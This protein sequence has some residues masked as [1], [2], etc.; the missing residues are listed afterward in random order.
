MEPQDRK[1]LFALVILILAIAWVGYKGFFALPG[2]SQFRANAKELRA[3]R[4]QLKERVENAEVQVARMD[5]IKREQEALARQLAE[6]SRRLPS[7]RESA[8]VLRGVQSLAGRAGLTVAQVRRRPER[9]QELFVELPMEVAVGGNYQDVVRF[10]D[11]LARLD[12]LVML[13]EFQIRQRGAAPTGPVMVAVE[14]NGSVRAQIVTVVFQALPNSR[15]AA[16]GEL[17]AANTQ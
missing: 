9:S 5:Q 8:E 16:P 2:V 14:T 1:N 15:P 4:T 17:A 3:E 12:R 11:A 7:Q 10:A 6:L 13:N